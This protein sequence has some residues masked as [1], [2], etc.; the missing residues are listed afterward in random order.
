MIDAKRRIAIIKFYV[1]VSLAEKCLA[2]KIT[3][4]KYGFIFWQ[5]SFIL[6]QKSEQENVRFIINEDTGLNIIP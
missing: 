2:K 1:Q 5:N 6:P 3:I 4:S